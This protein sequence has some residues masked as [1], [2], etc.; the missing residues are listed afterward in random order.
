MKKR[1]SALTL[2]ALLLPGIALSATPTTFAGLANQI[3]QLLGAATTDL[4]VLAIVIY[5]WGVS[6]SLFKQGEKGHKE[7]VKQLMWGVF[8]LFLAVTIWGIVQLVQ[9]TV[10]GSG[11]GSLNSNSSA[12]SCS[13]LTNCQLG[14]LH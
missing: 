3:V 6:S 7:L 1:A 11:V 8:V 4:I 13:G 12:P 2:A 5:F 10:F 14:Q 9:S